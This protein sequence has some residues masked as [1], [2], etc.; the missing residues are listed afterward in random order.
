LQVLL[1][2]VGVKKILQLSTQRILLLLSVQLLEDELVIN[3]GQT[4]GRPIACGPLPPTSERFLAAS[5]SAR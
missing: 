2:A 1:V 4:S 5:P 3:L